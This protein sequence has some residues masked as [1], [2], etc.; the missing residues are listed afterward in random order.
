MLTYSS[1]DAVQ[2]S[3]VI[4]GYA[5]RIV[6]MEHC[7]CEECKKMAVSTKGGIEE[8]ENENK[9]LYKIFPEED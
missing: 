9:Y 2:V 3:A 6:V 4:A 5:A 1:D 7:K 8:M